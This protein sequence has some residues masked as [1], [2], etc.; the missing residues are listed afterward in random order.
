M[1]R[2]IES[3]GFMPESVRMADPE[4]GTVVSVRVPVLNVFP[5]LLAVAVNVAKVP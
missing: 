2:A 3:P 4:A 5:V 1:P